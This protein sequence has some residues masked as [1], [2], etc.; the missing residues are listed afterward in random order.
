MNIN[1]LSPGRTNRPPA[2]VSYNFSVTFR[3]SSQKKFGGEYGEVRA[4]IDIDNL[5]TYLAHNAPGIE[6]PI[7]VKQFKV[8]HI[9]CSSTTSTYLMNQSSAKYEKSNSN[10]S[11]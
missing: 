10:R 5:N 7:K 4:S 8:G 1:D 9:F 11:K 2:R 3:M 6:T